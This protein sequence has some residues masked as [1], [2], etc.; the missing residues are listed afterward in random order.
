MGMCGIG[1]VKSGASGRKSRAK[2][3]CRSQTR[4]CCPAFGERASEKLNIQRKNYPQG[5]EGAGSPRNHT[6]SSSRE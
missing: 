3:G 6:L 5:P 1:I 2:E 4:T